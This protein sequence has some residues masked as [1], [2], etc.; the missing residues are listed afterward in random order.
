M[1]LYTRFKHAYTLMI[2]TSLKKYF[3]KPDSSYLL[4]K[5]LDNFEDKDSINKL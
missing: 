3:K 1:G 2:R 5:I 4:F